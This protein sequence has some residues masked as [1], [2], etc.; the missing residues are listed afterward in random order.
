MISKLVKVTHF[1]IHT[2]SFQNVPLVVLALS[3]SKSRPRW[4]IL[5]TCDVSSLDVAWVK[6]Y[7]CFNVSNRAIFGT[8]MTP[9]LGQS[10]P[11]CKPVL[12]YPK[13]H[14]DLLILDVNLA[15]YYYHK[16]IFE[17]FVTPLTSKLGQYDPFC[18][19]VL[20]LPRM[21]LWWRFDYN[22][23][24][25]RVIMLTSHFLTCLWPQWPKK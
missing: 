10:D 9:K 20:H 19:C 25:S 7:H 11:F 13:M 4:P 18:K 6:I 1:F 22:H 15:F 8:F 16:A 21:Q 24:M 2:W 14:L 12:Y 23:S 5:Q 17:I 3:D